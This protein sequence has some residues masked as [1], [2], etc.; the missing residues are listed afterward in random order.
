MTFVHV[1]DPW[2]VDDPDIEGETH[3]QVTSEKEDEPNLEADIVNEPHISSHNQT[4]CF[5]S[6][7]SSP[8]PYPPIPMLDTPRRNVSPAYSAENSEFDIFDKVVNSYLVRHFKEG[9]GQW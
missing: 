9:P 4:P 7:Q 8:L 2:A 5:A 3:V 1:D 6:I